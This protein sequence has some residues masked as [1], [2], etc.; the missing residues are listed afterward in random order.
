M[1]FTLSAPR[2]AVRRSMMALPIGR[3]PQIKMAVY[4]Q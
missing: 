1:D 2:E 3:D 4:S